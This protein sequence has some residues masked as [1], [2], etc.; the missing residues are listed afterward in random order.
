MKKVLNR[1]I[2]AIIVSGLISSVHAKQ[3]EN[4]DLL[5]VISKDQLLEQPY[6]TWYE[7]NDRTYNVDESLMEALERLLDGINVKVIMGTWCHDSKREVPRFYKI[8]SSA[9]A[10][11]SSVELIAVN[12]NKELPDGGLEGLGLTNTPTFVFYKDG[13]ELNRIVETPVETLEQDMISI[14]SGEEYRHSKMPDVDE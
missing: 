4:G 9:G 6:A 3:D 10:D 11:Q 13:E 8:L 1:I 14:L 7:E 12:R 2:V 5:G